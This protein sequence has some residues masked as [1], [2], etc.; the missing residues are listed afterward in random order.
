MSAHTFDVDDLGVLA[1]RRGVGVR[2]SAG[3]LLTY[4]LAVVA[5]DV[6]GT[7]CAAGGWLCDRVRAGW[8]VTVYVPAGS[9][10]RPLAI[11]GVATEVVESVSEALRRVSPAA[12]AM[13]VD[14]LIADAAV[15]A[16]V[17]FAVE[18]GATEVTLWGAAP[19]AGLDHRVTRVQ[20]RLSAAAEAFKAQAL[21]AGAQSAESV[22]AAEEFRSCAMWYPPES[23]DLTP[24]G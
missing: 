12:L 19:A 9:D 23:A 8:D 4:D 21:M 15:G 22:S 7:V 2:S 18:R 14:T 3:G 13:D 16:H 6:T 1:D 11:L 24:F 5:A 17:R 20:H 10:P